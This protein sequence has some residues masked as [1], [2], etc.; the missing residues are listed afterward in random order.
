MANK[1]SDFRN[2]AIL[3]HRGV[4]KT[5]LAEAM[6]FDSGAIDRIGK[7][8]DGSTSLDYD[9]EE[10]KRQIS[11]NMAV[12]PID[13]K[14]KKINLLD[15]PGDFDFVGEKLEALRVADS[16][17]I[18]M[19]GEVIVGTE[20]SWQYCDKL[21]LPRIILMNK[22][23]EENGDFDSSYSQIHEHFGN[24]AVALQ[25]PIR[26][27]GKL[28]GYVD[29]IKLVAKN[30]SE[31]GEATETAIPDNMRPL[32][33]E[34]HA[35][36]C[37][38]IAESDDALMEKFFNGEEFTT[39]EILGGLKKAINSLSLAPV[40]VGSSYDNIGIREMMDYIVDYLP[41]PDEKGNAKG[42]D[43]SG[44]EVEI[45]PD[46]SAP[47]AAFIFKTIADP[48]IGKLSL[49]RVYSGTVKGD[50]TLV[51]SRNGSEERI[52]Q[53]FAL[54]GKKQLPKTEVVAG[55][56]GAVAK[57][58]QAVTGDTLCDKSKVIA[59]PKVEFPKPQLRMAIVA[60]KKGDEEKIA[61]GLTKLMEEDKTFTFGT[62]PETGELVLSGTGDQHLDII[63]SKLQAK[64]G[65][66]V[67][68]AEPRM[69]YRETIT[70]KV[71]VQGKHKKQSGGHGQFGDVWIEFEP[72]TNDEL[73]FAE[74]V[75]GGSVPKNY[76]PAVEKGLQDCVKKGILAGYPVVKL[77]AT[78]VDGSY[79]PVDSSEMAFKTAASLAYK[80]GMAQAGPKL[81]EPVLTVKVWVPDKYMGDVMGDLSKRRGRV[82]GMSPTGD[83]L[84]EVV[85]EVPAGEM[86]KY[87]TDLKS[88]TQSRGSFDT[89][90]CRY[91]EVPESIA[92][93][94]I[95][96]AKKN[97]A[98]DD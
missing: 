9:P 8:E 22:M 19:Y 54:R 40:L 66:G 63:C 58:S 46:A 50:M 14:G 89:E 78:L 24:K 3:G 56:I 11:I 67:D 69:A 17:I 34:I 37:E 52:S 88:M 18:V 81:L 55:D 80:A 70:K 15:T 29:T 84:Q 2:V 59:L 49:F 87:A 30:Y 85:A 74:A 72:G 39:E 36:L 77:K 42:T 35:A 51:N 43:K 83:G 96:D 73:E 13:W 76:F 41:S 62:D 47:A 31:K 91:E 1:T 23:N 16:A 86:C 44:A 28:L 4:G 98:D 97:M 53:V 10:A 64:Y 6:L 25:L 93:K 27:G 75:F 5:A 71:K 60:R 20:K 68:L 26:E 90:F 82:L 38:V 32:A 95:E 61:Q 92:A 57:L 94:I 48:F 33:E 21:G 65:V 79:H 12:A 45:A 7:V